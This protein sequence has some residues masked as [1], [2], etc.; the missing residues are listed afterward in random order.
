MDGQYELFRAA[1]RTAKTRDESQSS[2]IELILSNYTIDQLAAF[3]RSLTGSAQLPKP[4]GRLA[5][6]VARLLDIQSAQEYAAL[7]GSLPAALREALERAVFE[8]WIPVKDLEARHGVTVIEKGR[9]SSYYWEKPAILPASRLEL[10]ALSEDKS[11]LA[12]PGWLREFFIPFVTKPALWELHPLAAAPGQS[13]AIDQGIAD[14][15]PLFRKAL[16]DIL[17]TME[18]RDLAR[19]GL[20]KSELG[21]LRASSGLPAFGA[22]A[23][24]GL[25]SAELLARFLALFDLSDSA[26][27]R[28]SEM[29]LKSLVGQFFAGRSP[30]KDSKNRELAYYYSLADCWFEQAALFDHLSRRPGY[31]VSVL[32]AI[33]PARSDFKIALK[34]LEGLGPPGTW[35]DARVLFTSLC[36]HLVTFRVTDDESER[37]ALG[38]KA[39]SISLGGQT[40]GVQRYESFL[41]AGE[42]LRRDCIARPIFEGYVYLFACLGLLEIAEQ[43]PPLPLLRKGKSEPISSADCLAALRLTPLGRWC[44]GFDKE[45]P[46]RPEARFEAIAD[47]ELL[48]VTFRGSSLERRLYLDLVAEP[49]GAERWR[50]TEAR[51]IAGCDSVARIEGR[52]AD[53]TRLIASESSPRWLSFFEGLR[54]RAAILSAMEA[55]F[56]I[57][58]PADPAIRRVFVDNPRIRALAKRVEDGSIVVRAD[59]LP[60]LAKLLTELGFWAPAIKKPKAPREDDYR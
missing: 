11:H 21:R 32:D 37:H 8:D 18:R 1:T 53:F 36:L 40:T 23:A 26:G 41:P 20:K 51:F 25:D 6:A 7:M 4:K 55:A 15:L 17:Q 22:A 31:T 12:L 5:G 38:I 45:R 46:P 34:L 42:T 2:R 10:F 57:P 59:R 35:V 9:G 56:V 49:L 28:E 16:G 50:F 14:I 3:Y 13:W 52:I 24:R 33:P 27:Q 44:L 39:E 48:I 60:A 30:T 58:L 29:F 19:K 54:R 47:E 43:E